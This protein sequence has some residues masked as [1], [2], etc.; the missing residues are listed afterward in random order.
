MAL[1]IITVNGQYPNKTIPVCRILQTTECLKSACGTR[2]KILAISLILLAFG[3]K[4]IVYYQS[5][6]YSIYH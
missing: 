3:E 2:I 4:S 6:R 1:I 5:L